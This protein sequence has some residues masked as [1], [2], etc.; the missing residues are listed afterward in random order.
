MLLKKNPS[1]IMKTFIVHLSNDFTWTFPVSK[2]ILACKENKMLNAVV[3]HHNNLIST[4]LNHVF[5]SW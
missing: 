5:F 4:F 1:K 2:L 3:C